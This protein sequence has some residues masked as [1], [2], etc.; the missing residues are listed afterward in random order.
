MLHLEA[1]QAT[2]I[3]TLWWKKLFRASFFSPNLIFQS[4][5]WCSQKS[6]GKWSERLSLAAFCDFQTPV[7][8]KSMLYCKPR[9][10]KHG[11][12]ASDVGFLLL[13]PLHVR[14]ERKL[15]QEKW[16]YVSSFISRPFGKLIPTSHH[17]RGQMSHVLTQLSPTVHIAQVQGQHYLEWQETKADKLKNSFKP[18]MSLEQGRKQ[19]YYFFTSLSCLIRWLDGEICTNGILQQASHK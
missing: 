12:V 3:L 7:H 1:R 2:D 19:H 10:L 4:S 13:T 6:Y 9:T 5:K 11:T 14:C 18:K 16:Q 15:R 8:L 17:S